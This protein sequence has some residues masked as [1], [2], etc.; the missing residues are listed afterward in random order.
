M[1]T[2]LPLQSLNVQ[3]LHSSLEH[4]YRNV[5]KHSLK[6][7]CRQKENFDSKVHVEAYE[8]ED[9][10]WLCTQVIGKKKSKMLHCP[11]AGP[12]KVVKKLSDLVYRIQHTQT[13]TC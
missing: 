6:A 8:K 11:W 13:K 9:L 12:F 1:A 4:N 7:A 10:V 3:I 2:P 5:R